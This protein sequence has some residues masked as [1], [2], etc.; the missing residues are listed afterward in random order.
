MFMPSS[1]LIDWPVMKS[2][3]RGEIDHRTDEIGGILIAVKSA[4]P[5][6]RVG[7]AV[8]SIFGMVRKNAF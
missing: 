2:L 5:V 4:V 8:D 7:G 3:C 6:P 1:M